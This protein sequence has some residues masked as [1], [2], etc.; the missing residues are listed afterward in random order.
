MASQAPSRVS[1]SNRSPALS[2]NTPVDDFVAGKGPKRVRAQGLPSVEGVNF[3]HGLEA[4]RVE[5]EKVPPHLRTIGR[6]VRLIDP[7]A[8]HWY[9]A[10]VSQVARDYIQLTLWS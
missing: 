5:I 2:E 4:I 10:R 3:V 6:V 9:E 7:L 8:N 1:S